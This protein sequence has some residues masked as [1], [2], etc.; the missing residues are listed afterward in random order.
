M[1]SHDIFHVVGFKNADTLSGVDFRILGL[2]EHVMKN[3]AA[4]NQRFGPLRNAIQKGLVVEEN[5]E[6]LFLFDIMDPDGAREYGKQFGAEYS[7]IKFFNE[8]AFRLCQQYGITLPPVLATITRAE[9]PQEQ[10]LG[11]SMSFR[12]VKPSQAA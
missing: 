9:L 8:A 10:H 3:M 5:V 11:T 1:K 2:S 6:V 7:E 12:N 4:L